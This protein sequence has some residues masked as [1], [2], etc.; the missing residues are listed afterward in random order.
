MT[1]PVCDQF[2]DPLLRVLG[3][4]TTPIRASDAC[5]RVADAVG[6]TEEERTERLPN[7]AQAT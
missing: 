4:C 6:L 7:G 2:I 1:I 3:A 5:Q